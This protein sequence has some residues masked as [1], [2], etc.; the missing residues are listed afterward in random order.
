MVWETWGIPA[1]TLEACAASAVPRT[2]GVRVMTEPTGL[3][4]IIRALSRFRTAAEELRDLLLAHLVMIGE[5][6]APTFEEEKRIEFLC[7]RFSD[8]NLQQCSTDEVGNAL[9]AALMGG[10]V[11]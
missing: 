2:R 5:I 9:G 6:P 7:Q 8:A 1:L 3:M 4:R 10:T 11:S